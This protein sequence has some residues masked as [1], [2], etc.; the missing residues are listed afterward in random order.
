M[1]RIYERR[2]THNQYIKNCLERKRQREIKR[3]TDE[4]SN[5][6]SPLNPNLTQ[7]PNCGYSGNGVKIPNVCRG[8]KVDT[9]APLTGVMSLIPG[10]RSS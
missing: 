10:S 2:V 4:K 8:N 6:A 7:T 5:K 9:V 1:K 3:L